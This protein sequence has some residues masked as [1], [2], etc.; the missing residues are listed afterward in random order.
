[1][2]RGIVAV[3]GAELAYVRE[4]HGPSLLVVGE[5]RFYARA[6]SQRLRQHYDLI[7]LDQ[8]YFVPG[9]TPDA[10]A[11][12]LTLDDFAEDVEVARRQLGIERMAVLGHG[13]NG[14][15][16]LAYARL[17]PDRTSHL[18]L[19]CSVPYAQ[20][21]YREAVERFYEVEASAQRK[22]ALEEGRTGLDAVLAATGPTK[23]FAVRFLAHGPLYWADPT[24]D[25]TALL[26]GV[27]TGPAF[28]SLLRA[29]PSAAVV[30]RSLEQLRLPVLVILGKLDFAIPY[31][32]WEPVVAGLD[33]VTCILLD[34][35]SH[36]PQA[37]SPE[38]FDARLLDWYR[39][40]QA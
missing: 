17:H 6:F 3:K 34:E 39:Q 18:I 29:V 9:F 22:R 2:T 38:R 16:A 36:I 27:E 21:D 25:A 23:Q 10:S 31:P 32:V 12:P 8:R 13:L 4:G 26:A 37:E 24:Y 28:W 1:M 19:A 33:H 15:V 20:A 7:F 35:D 11:A 30:R 40:H 14:Q 5:A